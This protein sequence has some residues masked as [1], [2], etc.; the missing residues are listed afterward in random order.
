MKSNRAVLV[1]G[2]AILVGAGVA[3][4]WAHEERGEDRAVRLLTTVPVPGRLVVFDISFINPDTQLYYLAD[5]SNNAIDVVDA[6]RNVF[7]KQI[8]KGGFVGFT[9]NNDTSGPNGVVVG[10]HWLFVTDG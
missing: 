2:I 5:R 4:A 7:V 9:G 10:G 3:P 1:L 8:D 6:K